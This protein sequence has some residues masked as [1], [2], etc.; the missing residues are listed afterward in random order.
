MGSP[1]ALNNKESPS[2]YDPYDFQETFKQVTPLQGAQR[3]RAMIKPIYREVIKSM[4]QIDEASPCQEVEADDF[5]Y[6]LSVLSRM[7]GGYR[8]ADKE[9][10]QVLRVLLQKNGKKPSETQAKIVGMIYSD[11]IKIR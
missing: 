10:G 9:L 7:Y 4:Q 11:M 8:T 5:C 2:V 1:L 3:V 6:H